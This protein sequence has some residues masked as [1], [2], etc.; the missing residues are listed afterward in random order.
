MQKIKRFISDFI[1]A[2]VDAHIAQ[3]K[4][5]VETFNEK[6]TKMDSFLSDTL[7]TRFGM[8]YMTEPEPSDFYDDVKDMDPITPRHLFIIRE[9]TN[10]KYGTLYVCYTSDISRNK[11]YFDCL[12]CHRDGEVI[13]IVSRFTYGY[14]RNGSNKKHWYFSGGEKFVFEELKPV[15]DT[16]RILPPEDDEDSMKDYLTD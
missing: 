12:I 4:P 5:D 10:K 3:L 1:E 7:K 15:T 13:Q 14:G 16:L 9:I 8:L 2:E 11:S 6:L